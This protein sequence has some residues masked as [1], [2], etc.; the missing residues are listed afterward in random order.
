MSVNQHRTRFDKLRLHILSRD[1]PIFVRSQFIKYRATLIDIHPKGP[2][3][4]ARHPSNQKQKKQQKSK[5]EDSSSSSDS[6]SDEETNKKPKKGMMS[7]EQRMA[8][9]NYILF[10]GQEA[11]MKKE[12]E[13][14]VDDR[15]TLSGEVTLANFPLGSAK[16]IE[17]LAQQ[18]TAILDQK[19]FEEA[20]NANDVYLFYNK[21]LSADILNTLDMV[22]TKALCTKTNGL[23]KRKQKDWHKKKNPSLVIYI[24]CDF[25]I[26][27]RSLLSFVTGVSLHK[28]IVSL[29]VHSEGKKKKKPQWIVSDKFQG[30]DRKSIGHKDGQFDAGDFDLFD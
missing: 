5:D 24:F 3:Q 11:A 12:V 7:Y 17:N 21:L 9:D 6:S 2:P 15:P 14:K 8:T 26:W 22:D 19:I 13:K 18:V 30:N 1:I 29:C 23:L 10:K 28:I 27:R 16:D 25:P 20:I 4:D